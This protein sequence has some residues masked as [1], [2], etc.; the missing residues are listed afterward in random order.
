MSQHEADI[1]QEPEKQSYEWRAFLFITVF[2][3]P[4]LSV[5]LIGGYGF[6]IWMSQVFFFGPP[7]H[8]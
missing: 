7:G 3:F 4:I 6:A 5:M 2:L 1:V 8:G